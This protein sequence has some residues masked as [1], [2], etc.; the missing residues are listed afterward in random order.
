MSGAQPHSIHSPVPPSDSAARLSRTMNWRYTA[1][2]VVG[3][4][5][6]HA[7]QPC[8]DA[9]RCHASIVA[10]HPLFVAVVAGG[11]TTAPL[12]HLGATLA[13]EQLFKSMHRWCIGRRAEAHR[14]D[15]GNA[16]TNRLDWRLPDV[17]QARAW[18][19]RT[20]TGL[21]AAAAR[22]GLTARHLACSLLAIV[23]TDLG[24]ACF[25]V[26]DG[27][28]VLH[29]AAGYQLAI[30]SRRELATDAAGFVT[31]LRV[32]D[33]MQ[34]SCYTEPA[35]G[36]VLMTTGLARHVLEQDRHMLH[37]PF[38]TSIEAG[39][40]LGRPGRAPDG[41]QRLVELLNSPTILRMTDEDK[42]IVVAARPSGYPTLHTGL[43]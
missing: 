30:T 15:P 27:A 20:H 4:R 5:N 18:A 22:R 9:S 34:Y 2:S 25:Q 31:D 43:T 3:T 17:A 10:G 19:V 13:A 36:I 41:A 16:A 35:L 39:L 1:A 6:T 32:L 29:T 33:E 38:L 23:A 26:G 24:T 14:V 37:I 11:S 7:D 8:R 40:D 21:V 42:T 28:I 12:S